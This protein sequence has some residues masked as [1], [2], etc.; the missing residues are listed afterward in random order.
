MSKEEHAAY[1]DEQEDLCTTGQYVMWC[2]EQQELE[3][4]R[5]EEYND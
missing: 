3:Q 5:E 2:Q 1:Y 4:N